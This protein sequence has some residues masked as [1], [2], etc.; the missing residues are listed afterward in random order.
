MYNSLINHFHPF[1]KV[2]VFSVNLFIASED[3]KT[4]KF[5]LFEIK[6]LVYLTC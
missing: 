6:F 5:V 3:G 1:D 2:D 4:E